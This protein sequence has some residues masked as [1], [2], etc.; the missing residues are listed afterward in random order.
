ML[1]D[2]AD[3]PHLRSWLVRALEPM[4]VPM[5]PALSLGR[6]ADPAPN[7]S[8]DADP[9]ALADYVAALLERDEPEADLRK[10]LS[11]QLDEFLE[12]GK[13]PSP[14]PLRPLPHTTHS[15]APSQT[16][17]RSSKASSPSSAQSPTSPTPPPTA[18]TAG[19]PSRARA[20][21]ASRPARASARSTTPARSTTAPPRARASPAL[22]SSTARTTAAGATATAGS[23]RRW[24][25]AWG[26]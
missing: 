8:C 23:R 11:A 2:A 14:A 18:T 19:S 24:I 26:I 15:S 7:A 6:P 16:A 9:G 21:P 10:D 5:L 22:A 20:P 12:K 17:R 3:R 25:W 13:A 1:F 4:S